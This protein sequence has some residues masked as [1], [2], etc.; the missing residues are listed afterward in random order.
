MQN[1]EALAAYVDVLQSSGWI[2]HSRPNEH[3]SLLIRGGQERIKVT[4]KY[5]N[6][7]RNEDY[8]WATEN[9]ETVIVLTLHFILPLRDD[10]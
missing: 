9:Y 5:P 1:G 8:F 2:E 3:T 4:T 10:C 7:E 6:I